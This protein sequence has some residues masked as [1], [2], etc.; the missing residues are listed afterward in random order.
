MNQEGNPLALV[1]G[2]LYP[3]HKAEDGGGRLGYS[4]VWPSS[5]V[6]VGH[7]EAVRIWSHFL[8]YL[9]IDVMKHFNSSVEPP[10]LTHLIENFRILKSA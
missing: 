8:Q 10:L 5:E 1:M 6:E 9:A 7:L 2:I 3:P 4:M